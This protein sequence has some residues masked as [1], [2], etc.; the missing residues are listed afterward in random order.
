MEKSML[1]PVFGINVSTFASWRLMIYP[2]TYLQPTLVAI[3]ILGINPIATVAISRLFFR[4]ASPKKL[5]ITSLAIFSVIFLLSVQTFQG[6]NNIL[7]K[8]HF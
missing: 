4:P 5:E 3:L 1:S 7:G 6:E 8:S 2:L